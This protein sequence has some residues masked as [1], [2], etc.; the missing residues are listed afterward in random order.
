[1]ALGAEDEDAD[2]L[3]EFLIEKAMK[4]K[5]L[6]LPTKLLSH[7]EAIETYLK[8]LGYQIPCISRVSSLFFSIFTYIYDCSDIGI[9]FI[10]RELELF[11]KFI[12]KMRLSFSVKSRTRAL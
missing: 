8:M 3:N 5:E 4:F 9:C 10:I 6:D 12:R 2:A 1:M 7:F 11:T